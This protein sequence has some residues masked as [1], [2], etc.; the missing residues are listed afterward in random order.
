M[1]RFLGIKDGM[2]A[3]MASQ[4]T[5]SD[6]HPPLPPGIDLSQL[7][8][9]TAPQRRSK[10]FEIQAKILERS[11]TMEASDAIKTKNGKH[12]K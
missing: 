4:G 8:P 12:K 3:S 7:Q 10:S 9:P 11:M 2:T 1:V 5:L 6:D